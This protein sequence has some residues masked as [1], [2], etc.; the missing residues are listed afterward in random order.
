MHD[1]KSLQAGTSHYMGQNFSKAFEIEFLGQEGVLQHAYTT[2][3]GVSTRLIGAIVM[4]HGDERGLKIPPVVA[5]IQC[6]IVPIAA[7]KPGVVEACE[8]LKQ[9][10]ETAGIR[11]KLDNSDNSPGWKFNEWEMKGVPLRIELGPRDIEAGKMLC[12]RRDNFEKLEKPLENAVESVKE[13][14][15]AI[16]KDMLESARKHRDERIVYAD[17]VKGI[18]DAV[19][20]GKFVKAGWCGCR[21]C[22]DKV[23]EETGATARVRAE[24]ES[25]EK[26]AICGEKAESV[27]IFARAY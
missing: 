17:D 20:G 22:E 11:V 2:S 24:G 12:A 23:K 19:D 10:L 25:A 4:T 26:C 8:A 7:R 6:V 21:A 1:G 14:L 27:I 15:D 9:E 13:L 5:P 18:L 3:W 16:Q